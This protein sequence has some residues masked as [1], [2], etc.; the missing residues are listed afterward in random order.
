VGFDFGRLA[1]GAEAGRASLSPHISIRRWRYIRA[2]CRGVG[3]LTLGPGARQLL[4][5]RLSVARVRGCRLGA[6]N[7]RLSSSLTRVNACRGAPTYSCFIRASAVAETLPDD[8]FLRPHGRTARNARTPSHAL[9]DTGLQHGG[10]SCLHN[11][12]TAE[13]AHIYSLHVIHSVAARAWRSPVF[14]L[15]WFG[16]NARG[17]RLRRYISA[18]LTCFTYDKTLYYV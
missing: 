4:R 16:Y 17:A 7:H 6:E 10:H 1:G 8:A 5:T 9:V 18:Q 2:R 13:L 14:N 3:A 11:E 15:R 12:R